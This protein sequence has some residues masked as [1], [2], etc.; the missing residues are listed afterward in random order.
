MSVQCN[1]QSALLQETHSNEAAPG[2]RLSSAHTMSTSE[3]LFSKTGRESQLVLPEI[4]GKDEEKAKKNPSAVPPDFDIFSIR[5]KERQKAQEERERMKTMK[6]HEKTTYSTKVKAKQK[7]LRQALQQEEKEEARKQATNEERL[8]A[9][10]KSLLRET[11]CKRDYPANKQTFRD[12]I[13]DIREI[14]LLE[15]GITVQRE[16]IQRLEEIA[17][18]E[19]RKVEKAAYC[20][21]KEAARFEEFLKESQK[22]FVQALKIDEKEV[23]EET[24]KIEEEIQEVNSEI[25]KLQRGVSELTVNLKEYRMYGK[26]LRQLSEWQGKHSKRN[27]ST[28]DVKTAPSATEGDASPP[29]TAEQGQ[30]GAAGTD[31]ASPSSTNNMDV[32]SFLLSS[33]PLTVESLRDSIELLKPLSPRQTTLLED[34]ETKTSSDEDEEPELYFTDPQQ[35]LSIFMEMEDEKFSVLQKSQEAE[36][37]LNKVLQ[38]FITTHESMET[39]IAELKEQVATLKSSIAEE[40]E[41]AA[42]LK[43]KAQLFSSG[44]G[45]ADDEDKILASLSEKVK[46]V[47]CQCTGESEGNLQ[48]V[49]MLMVLEK[50]LNDL[51]DSAEGIPPE[52]LEH[53]LKLKEKERK[54]KLREEKL[55]QQEKQKEERLKKA[56]E[57]SKATGE[58]KTSRRLIFRSVL[59]PKKPKRKPKQEETDKEKE[60]Q[61]YYFT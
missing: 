36:E 22:N 21:K 56:L 55:R 44:E 47:Y 42:D 4:P 31:A 26:F 20:L 8:K 15:F 59:P 61:L 33:K 57:R 37:S 35:L 19:E 6:I 17:R 28:R 12:Y 14:S 50:R 24:K 10:Q 34:A 3:S 27:T 30:G 41:R 46:E 16:E 39:E 18:N 60:E 52:K 25:K 1:S 54:I 53:A 11:A 7:E 38:T 48:T 49:Q 45:K 23:E 43:L 5:E 2:S 9:H 32:P 40:E 13:N 29:I 58:M 51:L